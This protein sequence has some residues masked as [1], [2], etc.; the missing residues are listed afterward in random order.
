MDISASHTFTS[1]SFLMEM[2]FEGPVS[3]I[4]YVI[5]FIRVFYEGV[6]FCARDARV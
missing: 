1:L 3:G 2:L 5:I 4:Y 6:G